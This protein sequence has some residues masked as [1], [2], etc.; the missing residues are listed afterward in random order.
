MFP[1][2]YWNLLEGV[3]ET[4]QIIPHLAQLQLY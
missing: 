4:P 1:P 3:E 2:S